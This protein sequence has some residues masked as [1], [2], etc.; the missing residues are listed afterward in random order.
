MDRRQAPYRR[1]SAARRPSGRC[2]ATPLSRESPTERPRPR[3]ASTVPV[4]ASRRFAAQQRN[5]IGEIGVKRCMMFDQALRCRDCRASRAP[6]GPSPKPL[7]AAPLQQAQRGGRLEQRPHCVRRDRRSCG[8]RGRRSASPPGAV[9][10]SRAARRR[11]G[12]ANRR[13]RR[14][15]RTDRPRGAARS[16]ASAEMRRPSAGIACLPAGESRIP[17]QPSVN[18][19]PSPCHGEDHCWPRKSYA[20]NCASRFG[21]RRGLLLHQR[22]QLVRIRAGRHGANAVRDEIVQIGDRT[23]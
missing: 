10:T 20:A 23:A 15:D 6:S 17:R 4:C 14:R 19:A 13:S 3:R 22:A 21:T 7:I 1:P 8:K 18:L 2:R 12:S 5:G 11:T 16:A 9:R